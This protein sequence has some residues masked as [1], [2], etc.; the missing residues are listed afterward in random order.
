MPICSNDLLI[1]IDW[2]F[3]AIGGF[4]KDGITMS[5][6]AVALVF[7]LNYRHK[8]R[9]KKYD[10]YAKGLLGNADTLFRQQTQSW[11]VPDNPAPGSQPS[12]KKYS[13]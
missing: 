2:V 13:G 7:L 1:C 9:Q 8:Q 4:L 5:C 11:E 3:L 10:E 6:L 12:D